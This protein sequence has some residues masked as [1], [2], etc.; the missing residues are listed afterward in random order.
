MKRPL[1]EEVADQKNRAVL[2]IL[3]GPTGSGKDTMLTKIQE[4][5]PTSVRIITT[6][7]RPMREN[8]S[9]GN[10]YHFVSREEFEQ[11]IGEHELFEWVEFRGEYM[12]TQRK[13]LEEAL[14]KG[15]NVIWRIDTKGVKNIKDKV[16]AMTDRVV[17]IFLMSPVEVLKERVR[18]DEGEE[19]FTRRWHESLVLW[20]MEQYD[21]CDYL[22]IN[23][24]GKLAETVQKVLAVME[25]KRHEIVKRPQ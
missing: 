7:S 22:V 20:E 1:I 19:G 3:T 17:F 14:A 21:D 13:T 2:L 16:R 11:K 12:G 24:E 15:V 4:A 18:R 8:E 9:Q 23:E 6:T 5:D 25:T 10:P